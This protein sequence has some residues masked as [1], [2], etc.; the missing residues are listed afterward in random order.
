MQPLLITNEPT[1][2]LSEA[3]MNQMSASNAADAVSTVQTSQQQQQ[4]L[5]QLG[6][7]SGLEVTAAGQM[8]LSN[9]P[10]S[11]LASPSS[12]N[13][14]STNTASFATPQLPLDAA[15]AATIGSQELHDALEAACCQAANSIM[16]ENR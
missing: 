1:L 15:T 4:Q 12:A 7:G 16:H 2:P 13:T 6:D 9:S 14:A 10:A 3:L 11:P 5:Q 8:V